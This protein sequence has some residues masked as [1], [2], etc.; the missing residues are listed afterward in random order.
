MTRAAGNATS[1]AVP[2]TAGS[3]KLSIVDAQGS[4]GGEAAAQHRVR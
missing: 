4:K 2:A 3:Y 1:I